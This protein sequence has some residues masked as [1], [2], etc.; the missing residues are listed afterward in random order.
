M[1]ETCVTTGGM[2]CATPC[3]LFSSAAMVGAAKGRISEMCSDASV[4]TGWGDSEAAV[5]TGSAGRVV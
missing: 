1:G 5:G 3:R 2:A 4:G